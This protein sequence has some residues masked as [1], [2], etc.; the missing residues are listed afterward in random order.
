MDQYIRKH[1]DTYLS[2]FQ[3]VRLSSVQMALEYLNIKHPAS[4]DQSNTKQVWYSDPHCIFIF[5]YLT[6]DFGSRLI[7]AF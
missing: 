3:M 5:E 6:Q 1:D 7:L 2:G 4:F